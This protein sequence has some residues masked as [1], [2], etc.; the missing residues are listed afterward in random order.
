MKEI[1]IIIENLAKEQNKPVKE[2]LKE[3]EDEIRLNEIRN[4][5]LN[6]NL[7]P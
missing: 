3:I 6:S 4:V 2:I 7:Q 1:S 5:L